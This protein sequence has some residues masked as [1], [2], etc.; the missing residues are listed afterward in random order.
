MGQ[1]HGTVIALIAVLMTAAGEA[2]AT[3]IPA[4]DTGTLIV[5]PWDNDPAPAEAA[6]KAA[7]R[8][9]L[10][11]WSQ[12]PTANELA[13][14]AV[15]YGL[16]ITLDPT[17][18]QL[19]GTV[20]ARFRVDA[21]QSQTVDL[22][23][24]MT[25][26]VSACRVGGQSVP[27][28]H[29]N[30]I[31]TIALDRVYLHDEIVNVEVDYSGSPDPS[32]YA[33]GWNSHL[34][35]PMIWTLSE[36]FGARSWWPC[37]DWTDDKVDSLDMR[38]TVPSGLIVA[39][40]GNLRE[41]IDGAV[42]DTYAWHEQYPIS[43]Y[44]V[45]L[46]I[47]PYTVWSD[48]YHYGDNDSMEV[49]FFIYPDHYEATR[50][51]NLKTKDMIA[52]YSEVFGQYPFIEE[53][54]GHAEFPAAGMEH[55]TCTSL[56]DFSEGIV[57]HE[58]AH[59]WWGDM[60]TCADFHHIWLNEGFGT[61]SDA[62]W[63][64]HAYGPEGY[65][66]DMNSHK[67]FGGG[68]IYVPDLSDDYRIFDTWLSYYKASWVLH[69]LRHV[70]GESAFWATL[71]DYRTAFQY[72]A[73]TTEDF[74][75]IAE[76]NGG[77]DLTDF[78]QQW[79]YGEY[80]PCYGWA[81]FN[82]DA[83]DT[84][85]LHLTIDQL[86]T[87]TG[88]FHMPLDIRVQYMGGASEG[89]VVD[90]ALGHQEYV[91]PLSGPA[92]S[93]AIDPDG[94]VLK[95]IQEPVLNPTFDRPVLLVNGINWSAFG[96]QAISAY[97]DRA[98]WGDL[99]IEFWDCLDEPE[100]GYPST[101]PEPRGH[102][103]VPSQILGEYE[104][105]IWVSDYYDGDEFECWLNTSILPYLEAG[106]NV[107]LMTRAGEDFLDEGLRDYL[108]VSWV[109]GS[110]IND[111]VAVHE[112]LTDI[113]RLGLQDYCSVFS[114]Q[115]GQQT[116]LLL[117]ECTQGY[118][119][120]VGIG[121]WRA[122]EGGGTHN[123]DGGNFAFLSGRPYRWNHVDLRTNVETVVG[124]LFGAGA[125]VGETEGSAALALHAQSPGIGA[126]DFELKLAP[127]GMA[128]LDIFDSQG[129]LVRA[130]DASSLPAGSSS[131][132]WNARSDE[133]VPVAAG[134]YFA[135]LAQAGNERVRSVLVIR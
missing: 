113:A 120:H 49:R 87:N 100:S 134:V 1:V 55:Q 108:G 97:Q 86:Q 133:G 111:C 25:L 118:E 8:G 11:R 109:D 10:T 80:Y 4:D 27:F 90:N 105:V 101:L 46:A 70:I 54:Y 106:G 107:L 34:G 112:G 51:I 14:D 94:W 75:A 37:D 13:M 32:Y 71:A 56:G 110:R 21:A 53:K 50:E 114:Q 2:A 84:W 58:L 15:Y 88:L 69:M 103:R 99:T 127:G 79:I 76:A 62:L 74:Q 26:T 35:Q 64:E 22:D 122:P 68:T 130:L 135:R 44:L 72:G 66:G 40:N 18:R 12:E 67:Y 124:T 31:L 30:E 48:Y 129:R 3:R 63:F 33:F 98:F 52:F 126:V 85:E 20:T 83:G 16:D 7:F 102:G 43:T 73:A 128:R 61:Y 119:P 47:H 39:S 117:W 132:R 82:V 24:A 36:P 9:R 28:T 42:T 6:A 104:S 91:L 93:V 77:V 95:R 19:G 60:V 23:L 125:A 131:V 45:S 123:P 116:S 81:W 78:F 57:C 38:V 29:A 96:E 115:L 41:F 59:Q 121:V 5:H 17:Q 92:E 89:F 65:W